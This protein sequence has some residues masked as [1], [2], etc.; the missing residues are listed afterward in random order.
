M[1]CA[2]YVSCADSGTLET[3]LLDEATGAL[4]PLQTLTLGGMLMPMAVSP[5]RRR[6]YVARRSEPLAAITLA[7]D[8]ATGRLAPLDE[9]AL[10]A[11]MAN[12]ATDAS[13]RWLFAASYGEHLVSISPIDACGRIGAVEQVLPAVPNAHSVRATPDNR[14]VFATSLGSDR[15][16]QFRFDV[17]RGRLTPNEPA[18]LSLPV[19]AGPRHL[20]F[21]P[22]AAWLYLLNELDATLAACA[23]DAQTGTLAVVQIVRT[24]PEGFAGAPWAAELRLT[25]DGRFLYASERRSS[26]LVAFAVDTGSGRLDRVGHFATQAQPRGF[27]ITPS[28]RHLVAA[29]QMSGRLGVHRIDPDRGTLGLVSERPVGGN[30]NWVEAVALP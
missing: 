5:D 18:A 21:H 20:A 2:V 26:T 4:E 13:G 24:L 10:P 12:I 22:H 3:I 11:S 16:L 14:F 30:P 1:A 25:P 23:L 8:A 9:Q 7:I 17:A 19:G 29:G 28:G 6:L 27:A 15:V